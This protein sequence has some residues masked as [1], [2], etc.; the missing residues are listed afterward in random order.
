MQP[1]LADAQ[2]TYALSTSDND[3]ACVMPDFGQGDGYIDLEAFGIGPTD[4]AGDTFVG[5]GFDGQNIDF[6]GSPRDGM[7]VTDD[8]FGFFE[9][10]PGPEPWVNMPIPT[11]AV[12]NDLTALFWRDL[13]IVA[14]P[15]PGSVRGITL[16]TA[17]TDISILEYDDVEP[18]PAGDFPD[19]ID[20]EALIW[21]FADDTPGA[22][23][24][25]YAY[26]NRVGFDDSIGTIGV[27]NIDGTAGTQYAHD[28]TVVDNGLIVCYD[29]QSTPDATATLTYQVLVTLDAADSTVTSEETSVVDNPGSEPVTETVS[30]V[31][32][33]AL[34]SDGDGV[35]DF[36]DNCSAFAN[37]SQCD[38]DTDGFGN[39]CDGDFNDSGFVNYGDLAALKMGFFGAS[40]PPA[41]NELDMDCDGFINM[42]DLARFKDVFGLPPGP[43]GLVD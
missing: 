36:E 32:N 40:P 23:E 37:P 25:V 2:P 9:S 31:V 17:G 24:I 30:V 1:S 14:D 28:D 16:A 7:S 15:T 13:E 39:H 19:R 4:L 3:P 29:L 6:F 5:T 11:A 43:S 27:E 34:D 20:F 18:F 38:S 35:L 22:Y 8:G 41:Y 21:G 42:K 33:A 10:E 26:D 12:P